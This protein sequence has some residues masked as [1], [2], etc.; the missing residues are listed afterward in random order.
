MA[1]NVKD[2]NAIRNERNAARSMVRAQLHDLDGAIVLASLALIDPPAYRIA[3]Y[4]LGRRDAYNAPT[5]ERTGALKTHESTVSA[6]ATDRFMAI[7]SAVN[8]AATLRSL[9]V[10]GAKCSYLPLRQGTMSAR[11]REPNIDSHKPRHL[12]GTKNNQARLDAALMTVARELTTWNRSNVTGTELIRL[13]DGKVY[14]FAASKSTCEA[15]T[16]KQL[17]KLLATTS[18]VDQVT[19][20]RNDETGALGAIGR[21]SALHD[22]ATDSTGPR[23]Y[24]LANH[25]TGCPRIKSTKKECTCKRSD[26]SEVAALLA[27]KPTQ[28]PYQVRPRFGQIVP[29]RV[30]LTGLSAVSGLLSALPAPRRLTIIGLPARPNFHA[31]VFPKVSPLPRDL[32]IDRISSTYP[33][34]WQIAADRRAIRGS[35]EWW[36]ALSQIRALSNLIGKLGAPERADHVAAL[37]VA[38]AELA[39]LMQ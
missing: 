2:P 13:T 24:V 28:A 17:R 12:L 7:M 3:R 14:D 33:R 27:S 19:S 21:G 10:R 31:L 20:D 26:P 18:K 5:P 39:S 16:D 6:I 15:M 32:H 1:K 25:V 34:E 22:R 4:M 9:Q 37:K 23:S 29:G 38:S 8:P 36:R 35:H 11:D 30:I